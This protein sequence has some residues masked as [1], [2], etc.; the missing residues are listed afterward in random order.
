MAKRSQGGG[1]CV[2]SLRFVAERPQLRGV[3]LDAG[4]EPGRLRGLA[5]HGAP[6]YSVQLDG[7]VSPPRATKGGDDAR[8]HS[9]ASAATSSATIEVST[10]APSACGSNRADTTCSDGASAWMRSRIAW[11]MSGFS[12]R[13]AVAF[14]RP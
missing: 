8:G 1:E 5:R 14:W 12:A 10:S 3:E 4:R 9:Y 2:E 13:K 11:T 7:D 6:G